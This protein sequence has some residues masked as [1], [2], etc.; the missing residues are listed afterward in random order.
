VVRL[1]R[2]CQIGKDGWHKAPPILTYLYQFTKVSQH[3]RELKPKPIK[4]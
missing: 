4:S 1:N 2:N 3:F